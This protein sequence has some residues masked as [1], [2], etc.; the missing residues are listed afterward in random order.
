MQVILNED[1][2]N[3]GFVGDIVNVKPGFARNYLFPKKI[4]I[5]ANSESIKL[6]EH[7]KRQVQ[8]KKQQRQKDADKLRE[9][10]DG[11]KV[12][13]QHAATEDNKLF[14]S[15]SLT[16]IHTKLAEAG[17]EVD[18]KLIRLEAPIKSLGEYD[19]EIK[20]HQDVS[21]KVKVIVEKNE[22]A[23]VPKQAKSPKKAA[24]KAAPKEEEAK[25][26]EVAAP[27]ADKDAKEK[28]PAKEEKS[29]ETKSN[30]S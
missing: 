8:V 5:E 18:R 23:E 7:R 28:A 12:T 9:K 27:K 3:L 2:T 21:A 14:G 22:N 10:I 1:Y 13:I 17:V 20:L 4:A 30:D 29:E 16:E 24:K 11:V 6:F 15:V 25:G 26:E 19:V